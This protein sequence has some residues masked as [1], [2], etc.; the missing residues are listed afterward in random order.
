M[1]SR[2]QPLALLKDPVYCTWW[3]TWSRQPPSNDLRPHLTASRSGPAVRVFFWYQ[4]PAIPGARKEFEAAPPLFLVGRDPPL[5]L[6]EKAATTGQPNISKIG[7]FIQDKAKG[8]DL[9]HGDWGV[10]GGSKPRDFSTKIAWM[11]W[12]HPKM[13]KHITW[14]QVNVNG[15]SSPQDWPNNFQ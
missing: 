14:C 11:D 2:M 13:G 4:T 7:G 9:H 15:S 3:F 6:Q 8:N 10:F 12:I 5:P 1:I